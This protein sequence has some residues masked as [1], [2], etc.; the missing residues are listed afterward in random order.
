E[1]SIADTAWLPRAALLFAHAATTGHDH[2]VPA[3]SDALARGERGWARLGDE[4]AGLPCGL[5]SAVRV[6]HTVH[7]GHALRGDRGG[8]RPRARHR[9]RLYEPPLAYTHAPGGDRSRL[10]FRGRPAAEAAVH[11]RKAPTSVSPGPPVPLCSPFPA[12][13]RGGGRDMAMP[14]STVLVAG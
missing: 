12:N 11:A 14:A 5:V 3:L 4:S 13:G 8:H 6:R 10:F 9:D 1:Q 7:P 2:P